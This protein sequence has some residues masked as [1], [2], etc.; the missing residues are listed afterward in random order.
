MPKVVLLPARL[1]LVFLV[2]RPVANRNP[3]T[4]TDGVVLLRLPESHDIATMATG[5]QDPEVARWTNLPSPYTEHDASSWTQK[6]NN[7]VYWWGEP[8]WVIADTENRWCGSVVLESEREGTA[9]VHFLVAPELRGRGIATR[10]VR[11]ACRWGFSSLRLNVIT[12]RAFIGNEAA[13]SV[14]QQSGF[15]VHDQI[16]R[17]GLSHRGI[18]KD[19]WF[20]DLLPEDLVDANSGPVWSGP[21]LTRRER[22]VLHAMAAGLSNR[23]IASSLGISENTVKNHVRS[24]LEKLPAK[25]RMEAVVKGVQEGITRLT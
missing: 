10:A 2:S 5:C 22:E 8:T 13:R 23:E 20:A 15:S 25:S 11:L 7:P 4:L 9:R 16:M 17:R 3:P 14:V 6:V 24:I 1:L 18:L 21:Q 12:W 19:C